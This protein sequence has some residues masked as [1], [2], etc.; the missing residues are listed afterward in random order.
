[1][2]IYPESEEAAAYL[3]AIVD[4]SDD[5]IVSKNLSG[6]IQTWNKG[7][8]RI[9]GYPAAEVIGKPI[10]V[11]IPPHLHHEEHT[12]LGRL[13]NGE[14][15]DHFETVRRRKDGALINI[16]LTVSPV[17]DAAG[18]IIGASKIARDITERKLTEQARLASPSRSS[19]LGMPSWRRTC[20][21]ASHM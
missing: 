18:R 9:F 16:S 20:R 2:S 3:A 1:M 19:L 7:A 14:R 4:S 21:L 5:A 17:R 10:L 13:R 15:I 11:I 12:I 8:E 6:I